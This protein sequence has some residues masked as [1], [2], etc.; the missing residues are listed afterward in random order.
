[1]SLQHHLQQLALHQDGYEPDKIRMEAPHKNNIHARHPATHGKLLQNHRQNHRHIG[2]Y[3][4]S[5]VEEL[6]IVYRLAFFENHQWRLHWFSKF[7][8][9]CYQ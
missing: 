2:K 6:K 1:M 7:F 3:P 5:F 9:N 4:G 8:S